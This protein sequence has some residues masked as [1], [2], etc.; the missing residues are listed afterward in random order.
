MISQSAKQRQR[1]PEQ[2]N[3]IL[4][5]LNNCI[6]ISK[7]KRINPKGDKKKEVRDSS[8]NSKDFILNSLKTIQLELGVRMKFIFFSV[9]KEKGEN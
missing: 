4:I 8:I 9:K 3:T 5:C 2:G 1:I 7:I 6:I